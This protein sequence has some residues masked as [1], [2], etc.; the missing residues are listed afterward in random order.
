MAVAI[1]IGYLVWRAF[2]AEAG[3][4]TGI[5]FRQR[6]A[7]LLGNTLALCVGV[8]AV[9]TVVALPLAWLTARTRI[10]FVR[11]VNLLGILPLAIPPYLMA[12]G[13]LAAGGP[14]GT[15][16]QLLGFEL[17]R[18]SGYTG[19]LLALSICN[20]PYL[21]VNLRSALLGLDPALEEAA[22]SLG[23]GPW[24]VARKVVW[25]QLRPAYASGTLLV[26][27]HVMSDF[28][29]V[30]LMR[31]E[32]FSYALYLQYVAAFDRT[33]AAWL[34]LFLLALT[35]AVLFL[36]ARFL[37]GLVLHRTGGG[38]ART[39]VKPALGRWA[40]PA[41]GF[42]GAVALVCLVIPLSSIFYW[43]TQG[44]GGAGRPGAWSGLA[45]SLWHS[46]SVSA[47]AALTAAVLAAPLAYLSVR[48]PG[49]LTRFLERT[50]YLGYA[51]PA[52][53]V[54]LGLIFFALQTAPI[55]YQTR[56]LLIYALGI[57]YLAEAM[58]P[59]RS[60]MY[61]AAPHLEES[62][63]LLGYGPV[64]AFLRATFPII[65]RGLFAAMA[66]VFLSCMKELPITFLLAPLN[67]QT[68][69]VN[70]WGYIDEA[71]FAEA[72]PY[73]LTILVFSGLFVGMLQLQERG[74]SS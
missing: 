39:H 65:Q 40:L 47:P 25:P 54:G 70:V 64:Q 13:Y 7:V 34:G 33:Y 16:A 11:W 35:G 22:R 72:A 17:P 71:M 27:L 48:Y 2:G 58:G 45:E 61:Q 44:G 4:L 38:A 59:V 26:W 15:S 1:P 57:H 23:H 56:F 55:L 69:A 20:F 31:Y 53:A 10:R 62:A 49:A 50:A 24:E 28:G 6:N 52:L 46:V 14:Y 74:R 37:R 29:V 9:S 67:Y 32:S 43:L 60:A 51:T 21:Y 8:L 68:L 66:F 12:Y 36:E 73:A 63:R 3:E 42:T 41:Y 18:L 19:A 30:S 5:V